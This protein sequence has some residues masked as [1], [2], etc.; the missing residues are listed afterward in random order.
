[1][2][3]EFGRPCLEISESAAQVIL[4]HP[5][6]GNVREL[7]NAIRRAILLA[8]DVIEPEH[9]SFLPL[10]ASPATVRNETGPIGPSL[11]EIAEG[12]ASDAEQQAIR[13]TLRATSG[14]KSEAARLLR[15]DYKTLHLKM[16]EYGIDARRYRE[17][18]AL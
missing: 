6:P 16:R 3:M 8:S 2:C 13:R 10:D 9:L 15:T 17:L 4:R 5:W 18:Q 11:K 7:R 12:A 14:N 1:A